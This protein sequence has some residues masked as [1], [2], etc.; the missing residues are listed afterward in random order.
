VAFSHDDKWL[1]TT[2]AAGAVI[3]DV[4]SG[5]EVTSFESGSGL[6]DWSA[7]FS[8]DDQEVVTADDDGSA[9]VWNVLSG[10]LEANLLGH[11][12][13]VTSAIFS[14]DGRLVATGSPDGT[15]RIWEVAGNEIAEYPN[16]SDVPA[17]YL[18]VGPP[19]D[20]Q[21]SA[22]GEVS[23]VN[24]NTQARVATWT[25]PRG[26]PEAVAVDDQ[27]RW[28]ALLYEDGTIDVCE[29]STGKRVASLRFNA[30]G[31]VAPVFSPDGR[32][33]VSPSALPAPNGSLAQELLVWDT[34]TW[35]QVADLAP[36]AG[37]G[38]QGG[39][40]DAIVFSPDSRELAGAFY[41]AGV[42]WD[43][44]SWHERSALVGNQAQISGL[45]FSPDG[46]LV[47]TTDQ[48]LTVRLWNASSGTPALPTMRGH[49]GWVR[50]GAFSPDGS[51]IVTASEDGTVRLWSTTTGQAIGVLQGTAGP[52]DDAQV[53]ANGRW[54]MASARTGQVFVFAVSITDVEAV[55]RS[56]LTRGFT[57]HEQVTYLHQSVACSTPQ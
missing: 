22:T 39:P 53:S 51:L 28:V 47:V 32:W 1:L 56:R 12:A 30:P 46:R 43:V 55:A 18:P 14:P 37:P 34:E 40:A 7:T 25:A 36:Q 57:C 31:V 27:A 15:A 11:T 49:D 44:Q 24:R 42:V 29:I 54:I 4:A 35:K 48:D 16:S 21:T 10:K 8:P 2:S 5:R 38:I 41:N 45:A 20:V 33:L 6:F 17:D 19:V 13:A 50:S 3:W 9:Q 26:Q 52:F 23:I